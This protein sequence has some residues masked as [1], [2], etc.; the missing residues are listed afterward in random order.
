MLTYSVWKN[1][2]DYI[3]IWEILS[4]VSVS[5]FT[6]PIDI[7]ISPLEIISIIIYKKMKRKKKSKCL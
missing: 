5:I 4:A 2:I 1:F 7:L 3:E 6:I